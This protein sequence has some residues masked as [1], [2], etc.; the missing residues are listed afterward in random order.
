MRR[1]SLVLLVLSLNLSPAVAMTGQDV[2][3]Y[4][5]EAAPSWVERM[6]YDGN[7]Q[8]E[9]K[10]PTQYLLSDQQIR[11]GDTPVH[12]Q[13]YVTRPMSSTG[14]EQESEFEISFNPAFQ[15]LRLHGVKILRGDH[16]R[17]V[18]DEV[19]IRV[20]QQEEELNQGIHSGLATAILILEDVQVDDIID[21]DYS[22]AGRNPI[23]D[24]SFGHVALDWGIVVDQLS[25]RLL[26][27][28]ENVTVE[29][30]GAA[31]PAHRR[32][33]AGGYTE[34]R[35]HRQDI[36]AVH[37]EGEYPSE[38]S[39][40][41]WLEYS[42]F[43]AWESVAAWAE[44]LYQVDLHSQQQVAAVARQLKSESSD[45]DDYISRAL[46]FVQNEIRYLGLEFGENSHLPH[47]PAEVLQK[48]YGD[49]KDKALLLIALLRQEGIEAY[50]ALVSTRS[51]AA[52]AKGLPS[53]GAFDHVITLVEFDGR[54]FWLDG[55]RTYQTGNLESL[56]YSDYGY[57]L[58]AGHEQNGLVEM[59]PEGY[60]SAR[61]E[62]EEHI[63]AEDFTSPVRFT[64][65]TTFHQNAA[66]YQR[67]FHDNN[68]LESIKRSYLEFYAGYMPGI[69]PGEGVRTYDDSA[70]NRFVVEEDYLIAD[71]WVRDETLL[72]SDILTLTFSQHLA[73]PSIKRRHSPLYIGTPKTISHITHVH[74]PEDIQLTL[75]PEPVVF[76]NDAIRYEYQDLYQN[77][78]YTHR[79]HL[80]IKQS[81][82]AP[83]DV[84]AHLALV[85][86]INKD[87]EFSMRFEDPA[88]NRGFRAF[89]ALKRRLQALAG[90]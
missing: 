27:R 74:Y 36:P 59:F 26:T 19:K 35:L 41:A 22:I 11:L 76:E 12:Y 90:D 71:Y 56:G 45:K 57:A 42:E 62:V 78:Q 52:I 77:S 58:L 3:G 54:R 4:D 39:P 32:A 87:W 55:T 81:S 51:R 33:A 17:D 31:V 20:I 16:A 61:V 38:Y 23:F 15:R 70:N 2:P 84:P 10:Q 37:D 5:I 80:E 6:P 34:Y 29:Q 75:D 30:F 66:E 14:V 44:G 47:S 86:E 85:D 46:F 43:P 63:Y 25:L 1:L 64:V 8:L 40:Y 82:V 73:K 69:Q 72:S 21:L 60:R 67:Y 13:R 50:P 7:R 89:E 24:R 28:D 18:L 68:P 83:E 53:P 9:V 48:R 79:A 88:T 65:K 49:C